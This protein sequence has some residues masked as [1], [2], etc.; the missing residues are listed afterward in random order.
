MRTPKKIVWFSCG[1]P[2]AVCGHLAIQEYG[3][4]DVEICYC[5]TLAYEHPD[6]RR[7]MKDVENWLGVP[8][9]ILKSEKYADIYDVFDKTGW[10]VGTNGARCTTELKKVVRE[11]YQ[12]VGD[13]HIF[14]LTLEE[15]GRIERMKDHHFD[16][17]LDF[18]LQRKGITK[19][20]CM[21]IVIG[22]GIELPAMYKLGYNNNNCIGCVKGGM[23]YWN[24]IRK[25][26][27][28]AFKKMAEQERKMGVSCLKE[29][30]GFEI[31]DGEPVQKYKPLF[32]DELNPKRGDHK[33][34]HSFEC[35]VMCQIKLNI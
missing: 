34:E 28:D 25:D 33:T 13:V 18:I 29:P 16:I 24:K 17:E 26:F 27:P 20:K 22:A 19:D 12:V 6:N 21:E 10:L 5:D 9:K 3:K 7:F 2:S 4:D 8:I 14:G 15:G 31:I 11:N 35:G 1:A 32:L 23:G 30:D